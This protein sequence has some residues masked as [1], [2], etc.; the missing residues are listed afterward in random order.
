[1]AEGVAKPE[2]VM[3]FVSDDA[4]VRKIAAWIPITTEIADDAPTLRG[5]IDTRLAY[6]L[7]LREE[8]EILSGNGISPDLRVHQMGDEELVKL[9]R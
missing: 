8:L 6:M 4:P 7:A 2:V 1:M 5:Y 3:Q 9:A